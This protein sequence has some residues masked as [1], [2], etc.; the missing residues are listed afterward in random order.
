M[1]TLKQKVD[2]EYAKM[3]TLRPKMRQKCVPFAQKGFR[4][5]ATPPV[6]TSLLPPEPPRG[7]LKENPAEGLSGK[8]DVGARS[9]KG[10]GGKR[11][12]EREE[13][14]KGGEE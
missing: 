5:A 2:V 11:C 8:K 12:R 4:T 1:I 7:K 14:N 6:A 10:G 9:R 13:A 3:A